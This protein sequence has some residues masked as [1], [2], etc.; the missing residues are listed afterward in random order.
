MLEERVEI[1]KSWGVTVCLE[2]PGF[3]L[4]RSIYSAYVSMAWMYV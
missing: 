2:V 4:V 3:V 1:M